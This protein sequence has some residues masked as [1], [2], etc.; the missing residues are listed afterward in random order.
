MMLQA[1]IIIIITRS[2]IVRVFAVLGEVLLFKM[3]FVVR[4]NSNTY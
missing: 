4:I 3:L 2:N 1:I